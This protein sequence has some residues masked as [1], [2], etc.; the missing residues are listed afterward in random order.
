M[1][2]RLHV[3][4]PLLQG[5]C[6]NSTAPCHWLDLRPTFE[7]HYSDYMQLDGIPTDAGAQAAAAAVWEMIT[8]SCLGK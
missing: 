1:R 3:I 4:R 6:E 8:D 7:G 2:V 5:V